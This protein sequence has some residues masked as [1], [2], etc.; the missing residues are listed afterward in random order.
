MQI[1]YS[2]PHQF[3]NPPFELFD[4]SQHMPYF[5]N[6]AIAVNWL[7]A[8]GKVALL[9]IEYHAGNGTQDIFYITRE[10]IRQIGKH[11]SALRLPT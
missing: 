7:S 2:E 1:F 3:H 10:G 4:G 11:I 6:A 5:N 9:D 8:V